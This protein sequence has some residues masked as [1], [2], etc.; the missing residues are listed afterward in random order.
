MSNI[1]IENG[2]IRKA[3]QWLGPPCTAAVLT[4]RHVA[5]HW[6]APLTTGLEEAGHQVVCLT[7]E[8]GE[9]TKNLSTYA[10]ILGFLAEKGLTRTDLVVALGGGVVGDVGGFAAA[11]YLRG[12][13]LVQVP[14]SLLAQVDAA[15]G[16]KTAIDLPAG[17]NLAGAFYQPEAVLIDAEALGT[18]PD[19]HYRDGLA[20]VVKYGAIRDSALL[21]MLPY[22]GE[23]Q[24]SVIRRC[25]AIKEDI[26]S[27]DERDQGVRQLLNFGHTLGHA[28][29][30]TSDYA[31]SHGQGVAMGMAAMARASHAMGLCSR[32]DAGRLQGLLKL[33]GLP[34]TTKYTEEQL[35]DAMWRDKKRGG[36]HLTLVVMHALGDCRLRAVDREEARQW[37]RVGLQ[38]W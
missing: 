24:L 25:V 8:P 11:T 20:E 36:R 14:T 19:N 28:I 38:P 27:R 6:L 37:L 16:G 4:D 2:A 3:S 9:D 26:V 10:H 18:L 22:D 15:I 31:I 29:E 32:Q 12:V 21:D 13:R 33:L 17:K 7:L 23:E 35:F 5:A 1:I 34:I 30:K